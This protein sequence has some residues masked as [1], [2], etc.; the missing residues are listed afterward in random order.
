M[1]DRKETVAR[2]LAEAAREVLSTDGADLRALRFA[3]SRWEECEL[4]SPPARDD[5]PPSGTAPQ[6]GPGAHAHG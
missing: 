4:V 3:L 5:V 1:T 2:R 6:A